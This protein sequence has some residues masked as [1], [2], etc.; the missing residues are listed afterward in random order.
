MINSITDIKFSFIVFVSVFLTACTGSHRPAPVYDVAG[1]IPAI[2]YPKGT[3]T[4]D[5]YTVKLGETLYSIAWR[6]NLDVRSLAQ[7]NKISHPYKIYPGQKIY[8]VEKS[9]NVTNH[10]TYKQ[11]SNNYSVKKRT[12]KV[13]KA[14]EPIKNQAYGEVVVEQ[15]ANKIPPKPSPVFS[16]KIRK[17]QWPADGKIIGSFSTRVEGNKG[18]DIAGQKGDKIVAAADGNVV[19][20]GNGLRGYGRLVIIKHNDDYLSAYAH[21]DQIIVKEQQSVKAGEYI[22]KMGSS[23]AQTVMLHFEVRFRGKSVNPLKYLPKK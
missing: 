20:V 6:A 4:A 23:D 8:L 13:M 5:N 7:M 21:N 17:W 15:K 2:K 19:Y 1:S 12:K 16:T 3:L 10:K 11:K 18:I 22:A 9:T 14:I